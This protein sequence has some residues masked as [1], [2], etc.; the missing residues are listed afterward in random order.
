MRGL[1]LGTCHLV[2]GTRGSWLV[3]SWG[4]AA[5]PVPCAAAATATA[6][7]AAAAAGAH[8]NSAPLDALPHPLPPPSPVNASAPQD[9]ATN[10]GKCSVPPKL[11]ALMRSAPLVVKVVVPVA[12]RLDMLVEDYAGQEAVRDIRHVN[13]QHRDS[14]FVHLCEPTP[15]Q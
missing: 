11:Y 1:S 4:F 12:A 5:W 13:Y 2:L 3:L 9:E 7:A 14:S 10:V 8:G 15:T 6:A